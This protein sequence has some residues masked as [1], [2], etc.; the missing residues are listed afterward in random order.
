MGGIWVRGGF[1]EKEIVYIRWY[2]MILEW[3]FL[4]VLGGSFLREREE[5]LRFLFVI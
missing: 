5:F 2:K 1:L 4:K 3:Y